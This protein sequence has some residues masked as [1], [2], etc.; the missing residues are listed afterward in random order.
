[1]NNRGAVVESREIVRE[2][3]G[4]VRTEIV[5]SAVLCS[6]CRAAQ[7]RSSA[8]PRGDTLTDEAEVA[9]GLLASYSPPARGSR[10]TAVLSALC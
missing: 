4:S 7:A 3:Q 10:A 2:A 1:M 6:G 5:C 8:A 9:G